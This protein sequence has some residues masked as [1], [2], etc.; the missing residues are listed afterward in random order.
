LPYCTG[1]ILPTTQTV[2]RITSLGYSDYRNGSSD[3]QNGPPD[4]RFG[5]S[6]HPKRCFLALRRSSRPPERYSGQLVW[7]IPTTGTVLQTTGLGSSDH[8]NGSSDNRFRSSRPP[9]RFSGQPVWVLQTSKTVLFSTSEVIPTTETVLRTTGLGS[10]DHRNGPPNKMLGT[11]DTI[12]LPGYRHPL[13]GKY[14][15]S[16]RLNLW[17]YLFMFIL[18]LGAFIYE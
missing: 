11:Y 14:L 1:C 17:F 18:V 12:T 8:R 6:K 15:E 9:E 2:L 3:H 16:V 13:H 5:F 4:N 10:S 7:V